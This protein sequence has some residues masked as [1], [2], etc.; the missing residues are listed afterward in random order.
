M[1][2]FRPIT[3]SRAPLPAGLV[4]AQREP[5]VLEQCRT[6]NLPAVAL[7]RR[8]FEH[9]VLTAV[10]HG[11]PAAVVAIG[12][13][14]PSAPQASFAELL[15][16]VAATAEP[17]SFDLVVRLPDNGLLLLTHGWSRRMLQR[18]VAQVHAHLA[19]RRG[20]GRH[21][22]AAVGWVLL[23]QGGAAGTDADTLVAGALH[24]RAL[25]AAGSCDRPVQGRHR[26]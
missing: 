8:S 9:R 11:S 2:R 6:V 23:P 20:S 16:A 3:T 17:T 21:G 13:P 7:D 24:G 25:A 12:A 1:R 14:T 15:D 26:A 19:R 4:P 10:T 18:R 22:R 5:S